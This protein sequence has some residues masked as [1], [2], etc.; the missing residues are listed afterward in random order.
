MDARQRY[1]SLMEIVI[2]EGNYYYLLFQKRHRARQWIEAGLAALSGGCLGAWILYSELAILYAAVIV[3]TQI[4]NSILP[5]F[6]IVKR[7]EALKYATVEFQPI[8]RQAETGWRRIDN[9]KLSDKDIESMMQLLELSVAN[10]LDKLTPLG[11]EDDKKICKAAS[12]RT[13]KYIEAYLL[14]VG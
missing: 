13:D 5:H 7:D 10:V 1:F 12:E 11:L 6:E 8:L 4:I 3:L 14:N 2:Y 9:E